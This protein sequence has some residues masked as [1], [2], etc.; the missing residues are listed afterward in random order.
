[1]EQT[2][3]LELIESSNQEM[4][5]L[6]EQ[7]NGVVNDKFLEGIEV[8]ISKTD[9]YLKPIREEDDKRWEK[10]QEALDAISSQN[11]FKSVWSMSNIEATQINEL[12][13][14]ITEI[15]YE[16]WGPTQVHKFDKPTQLTWLEFWKLADNL[17]KLSGD[18]H[19]I[20]IESLEPVKGKPGKYKLW[21]GS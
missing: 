7:L 15:I 6:F 2:I 4:R 9:S 18:N 3:E 8:M 16:S 11:Q 19:H 21:T 1:M 10:N 20:F 12:T 14:E 5:K 17:I 13:P